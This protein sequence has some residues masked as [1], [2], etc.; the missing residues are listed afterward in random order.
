MASQ[1]FVVNGTTP[2]LFPGREKDKKSPKFA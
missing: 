1:A 2:V